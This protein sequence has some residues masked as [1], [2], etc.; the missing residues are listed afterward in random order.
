MLDAAEMP[1]IAPICSSHVADEQ[2]GLTGRVS[3]IFSDSVTCRPPLG[4]PRT[5]GIQCAAEAGLRHQRYSSSVQLATAGNHRSTNS[6]AVSHRAAAGISAAVHRGR[7]AYAVERERASASTYPVLEA[8]RRMS[9]VSA[10]TPC[11]SPSFWNCAT[12]AF[13]RHS[14][15]KASNAASS[16]RSP[17]HRPS[18]LAVSADH[19]RDRSIVAGEPSF[20]MNPR[21]TRGLDSTG[22]SDHRT[23]FAENSGATCW[24]LTMGPP[25]REHIIGVSALGRL[26]LFAPSSSAGRGF[27]DVAFDIVYTDLYNGSRNLTN[28]SRGMR[29]KQILVVTDG[30]R[31]LA[32][33]TVAA[34]PMRGDGES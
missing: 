20:G 28:G 18:R 14:E 5:H 10:S 6:S 22:C 24:P 25:Q 11:A 13:A 17:S 19:R 12:S 8:L 23:S 16:A 33:N 32:A 1:F 26:W 21:S 9:H 27:L 34:A 2:R 3:T 31:D 30:N 4:V 7:T 15:S 29:L